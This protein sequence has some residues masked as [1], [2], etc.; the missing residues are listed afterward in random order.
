MSLESLIFIYNYNYDNDDDDDDDE[1]EDDDED[2][3]DDDDDN[4]DDRS[5]LYPDVDGS[6]PAGFTH[7]VLLMTG[8]YILS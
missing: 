1:D 4:D 8:V 7:S 5:D 6:I 2:D 3:D